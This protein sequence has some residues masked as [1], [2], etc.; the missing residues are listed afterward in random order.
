MK[1][2]FF[3]TFLA[4]FAVTAALTVLGVAGALKI[5]ETYLNALFGSLILELITAMI[6][7]FRATKFF[8]DSV[9]RN[10]EEY[11]PSIDAARILHTLLIHQDRMDSTMKHKF[12]F[13]VA[14]GTGDFPRFLNGLSELVGMGLVDVNR[15]QWMCHFTS[16]GYRVANQKKAKI[17]STAPFMV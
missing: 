10:L 8:D 1:K 9:Y 13:V 3:Y 5:Q 16:T 12:G 4:I 7:L 14:P 15:E 6:A 17:E 2:A 11:E